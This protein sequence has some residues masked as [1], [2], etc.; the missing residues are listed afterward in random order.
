MER[1]SWVEGT[2]ART[3]AHPPS[4][5]LRPPPLHPSCV[6]PVLTV[7][8][9]DV[10]PDDVVRHVV[11]IKPAVHAPHV[12]LV[13]V[14]P[15]ALVVA[16]GEELGQG[17]RARHPGELAGDGG[18]GRPREQPQVD[19]AGFRHP[20]G[21][22]RAGRAGRAE[23]VHPHLG[24]VEPQRAN[25]GRAGWGWG[26]GRA[27]SPGALAAGRRRLR[28]PLTTA[29]TGRVSDHGRD[30]AVQPE[31]GVGLIFKDVEVVQAV[32]FGVDGGG[33]VGRVGAGRGAQG[34]RGGPF[35]QAVQGGPRGEGQVQG[36]RLRT[37]LALVG[38]AFPSLRPRL[39]FGGAAA[40]AG[41]APKVAQGLDV[42]EA[43]AVEGDGGGSAGGRRGGAQV[44]G[45]GKGCGLDH[46]PARPGRGG[47]GQ[48]GAPAGLLGD[49]RPGAPG[50][51][52]GRR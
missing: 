18:G 25:R 9:L 45:E 5:S 38:V 22:G 35:R 29:T 44:E 41:I 36:H 6:S 42:Q 3:R 33:R 34:G 40:A 49:R 21:G 43:A 2:R 13:L 16:E 15:P 39:V 32:G 48:Q 12:R 28:T 1:G 7:R 4:L 23:Q 30:G 26:G 50:P 27:S 14:V 31:I 11:G 17:G 52:P 10:Q 19:D 47:E 24:R 37:R 51:A 46:H 8:V 20:P